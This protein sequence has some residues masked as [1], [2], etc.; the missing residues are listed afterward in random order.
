MFTEHFY[1]G[2]EL[3][4]TKQASITKEAFW[5]RMWNTAARGT[6][7]HVGAGSASAGR[8]LWGQ[9]AGAAVPK[10]QNAGFGAFGSMAGKGW[11]EGMATFRNARMNNMGMWDAARKGID[12]GAD[13]FNSMYRALGSDAQQRIGR[14]GRNVGY[15]GLFGGGTLAAGAIV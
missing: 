15:T 1:A 9:T 13:T 14:I 12:A 7:G 8:Q 6:T 4:M 10:A 11:G 3:G 2:L 5:G